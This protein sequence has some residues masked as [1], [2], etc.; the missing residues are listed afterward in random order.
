[1]QLNEYSNIRKH[2]LYQIWKG[3]RARCFSETHV[4]YERYGGRGI[5]PCEEWE[6]YDNFYY[7]SIENG[8]EAHLCLDRKDNDGPYSPDNCRWAT[9][10]E[11]GNNTSANVRIFAFGEFKT[12]S[13]WSED[14]RC[15]V[16]LN[17]LY[18]RIQS[19]WSPE[20]AIIC[21]SFRKA[22]ARP[23]TFDQ[24]QAVAESTAIYPGKGTN[25]GL[26]YCL[27]GLASETGELCGKL[28][29]AIRD[30]KGVITEEVRNDL[31]LEL[32]D[33][34]WYSASIA[35]E[36]GM[37]LRNIAE[38]NLEKLNRRLETDTIAGSGDHRELEAVANRVSFVHAQDL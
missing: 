4:S 19:E 22:T 2:P 34:L 25:E 24:Y 14:I 8:W 36:L 15:A 7:W 1:M 9:Y 31:L 38:R 26:Q 30:G 29:K 12:V 17:T 21:P 5:V 3:M 18:Q 28:K 16:P 23:I 37:S 10:K 13:Q 11:Q 27:L 32:S 35:S 33:C 20:K 6:N